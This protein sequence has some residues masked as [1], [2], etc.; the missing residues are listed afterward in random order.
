MQKNYTMY[1]FN[2]LAFPLPPP[3][4]KNQNMRESSF[5]MIRGDEDIE[6]AKLEI[7]AAPLTSG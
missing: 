4:K 7:L 5:D 6:T 3:H 1:I 2:L